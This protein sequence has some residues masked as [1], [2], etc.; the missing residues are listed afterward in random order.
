VAP[1]A[2][3]VDPVVAP[4]VAPADA[5]VVDVPPPLVLASCPEAEEALDPPS[6]PVPPAPEGSSENTSP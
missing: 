5:L 1:L 4:V 2:A 3:V 6:P